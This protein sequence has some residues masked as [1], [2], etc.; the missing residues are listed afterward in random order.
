VEILVLLL[1]V[2]VVVLLLGIEM[3]NVAKV[4]DIL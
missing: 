4:R 1:M 2:V 3:L